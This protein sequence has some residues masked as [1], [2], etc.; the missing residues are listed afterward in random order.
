MKFRKRITIIPGVRLN[1]SR[2]GVSVTAGIPG[3][4]VNLGK[5]GTYLNT[6][7]PGTGLYERT[8]LDGSSGGSSSRTPGTARARRDSSAGTTR[9]GGRGDPAG[10]GAG[11]DG[12]L[13]DGASILDYTGD[14]LVELLDLRFRVTDDG[15]VGTFLPDGEEILEPRILRKVRRSAAFRA[16]AEAL[17]ESYLEDLQREMAE[18]LEVHHRTPPATTAA[19][20]EAR[21]AEPEPPEIQPKPYEVPP[22]TEESIAGELHAEARRTVSWWPVWNARRRRRDYVEQ[23]MQDRVSA[24]IAR[25]KEGKTQFDQREAVRVA[26]ENRRNRERYEEGAAHLRALRDGDPRAIGSELEAL[27]ESVA[28]PL[29]MEIEFSVEDDG[30]VFF[31]VDL[32]E[33][34]DLPDETARILASGK[35]SVK[36]KSARQREDEYARVV[37][38]LSL[39]VGGYAF[40]AAPSVRYAR[41]RGYTRRIDP[42]TGRETDIVVVDVTFDRERFT[43]LRLPAGEAVAMVE[44]FSPVVRPGEEGDRLG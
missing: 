11:T 19:D 29:P 30:M 34:E 4:S 17:R 8:R 28:Y 38:A 36:P 6:G 32:P 41:V 20:V 23:R 18:I 16:E 7:I 15:T 26:E 1:L 13:T 39:F 40:A 21:L 3:L 14:E 2:S 9:Q 44:G 22:P 35:L 27:L 37:A 33:I 12:D 25:W 43:S 42:A 31:D 10:G 24:A 5:R